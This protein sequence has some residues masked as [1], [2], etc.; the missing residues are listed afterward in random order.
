MTSPPAS[1]STSARALAR[2]HLTRAILA[3]AR[4]QLGTVGPAALS[5][6]AVARDVGM[7]SSAVYR[8]FASRDELLTA[9]LVECFDEHGEAVETASARVDP[10]DLAGRWS[11]VAHAF[12]RWAGEH[13][14]DYALLYGSPVPGYV[15]PRQTVAPATRVTRL[16]L[17]LLADAAAAGAPVAGAADEPA[18]SAAFHEAVVGV[19]ELAG[20]LP[21]DLLRAG[22]CSWAGLVGAVTLELFGHLEQAVGDREAWF[23]AVSDRLCPVAVPR[24]GGATA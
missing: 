22:L 12:R 16:L 15:A 24:M 13:P 11:A 7:A 9:L 2:D 3:S 17:T 4:A 10:A 1:A 19:R 21:D 14:W 5:V 20:D 8:Y 6:R 18:P 23:D